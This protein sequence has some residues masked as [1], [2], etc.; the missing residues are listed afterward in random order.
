VLAR[1]DVAQ[2]QVL[3]MLAERRAPREAAE[4]RPSADAG[5]KG[6]ASLKQV[7]DRLFVRSILGWIEAE[8]LLSKE[9]PVRE[10][11]RA[12][13]E[14]AEWLAG[15]PAL[16]GLPDGMVIMRARDGTKIRIR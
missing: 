1:G 3:N 10:I 4:S 14:Y 6:A 2:S 7:G 5:G 15:E 12:S 16:A 11:S 13:R 9:A 8:C